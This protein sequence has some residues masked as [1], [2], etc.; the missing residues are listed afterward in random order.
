MAGKEGI[1][2]KNLRKVLVLALALMVVFAFSAMAFADGD[3]PAKND[4]ITVTGVKVGETYNLY[5]MF[6]LSVNDEIAPTAYTYTVNAEWAAF[7]AEGGDGAQYV[8]K[9]DAGAVT[10]I[11]DA[12]ALAKAA[13]AWTGKPE[14]KQSVKVTEGTTEVVFS[15]LED[16]YWLI[17]S[18]LGTKAMIETTPD[19]SAV[20]V[21]EKNPEDT[22]EKEVKED[23]TGNYGESNDVQIGDT[24]EF[25]STVKIVKGTRNVVVHDKMTRGLT[26]TAESVNI[27]GLTKGTEYTVNESPEDGDTFD[28]TFTQSWIDGLD[29]GTDGFK[30]YEI[31][32]KAV[33]NEK[34]VVKDDN[35]VAIVDA[36]NTT[37]VS[38]GDGTSS[39]SDSTTTTTHKFS[40]FK[41]AK[42]STDNL[43]DA[44][45]SLKKADAVV[46][47][48][49]ID[50]NNYRIAVAGEEGAVVTFTTVASGDIIIWGVDSDSDY[51]LEEITPP[52]GYN[53]LTEDVEVTV[54]AD[55][56][57]RVDVENN[58]GNE[59]PSTGGVGTTVFYVLGAA[60]VVGCGVVLVSRKRMNNK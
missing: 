60:L 45:F 18:T 25:K 10:A 51:S 55:N 4:S 46:K 8:T 41:H 29:F 17:T 47:L 19:A 59:L 23:S 21:N 50:D 16:G 37:K 27:Q 20:T 24:V 35:G 30:V 7:F 44:V 3:T 9:N 48:I 58:A 2:M 12:A 13:A 39:G 56:S 49:K 26:Y 52:A 42:D 38:F 15:G 22:I 32:Y 57:T 54:D 31:T 14:P 43:A 1:F 28:I 6:D 34:A 5:K 11:S 33:V 36:N 40:V 53:K